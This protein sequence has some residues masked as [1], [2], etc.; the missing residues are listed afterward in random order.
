MEN[1]TIKKTKK[2]SGKWWIWALSI[3]FAGLLVFAY[4][5]NKN[6]PKGEKVTTEK[7]SKRTIYETVSA[8]G[9][10]FPEKEIKISSDVSGEVV[11][12]YV[13]EGDSVKAGQLLAKIN[14]DTYLSAVERGNAGVNNA[15][16]QAAS[17]SAQIETS[18][19]Q[20]EQIEANLANANKIH[21]R[22]IELRKQGVISQADF[23]AS[24][25]NVGALEANLKSAKSTLNSSTQQAKAAEF[26]VKSTEASLKELRTSLSRTSIY[27][28]A[29]GVI[30]KLNIEQ[31]ERVV[32]TIQ[33]AGTE[34]MRIANLSQMEVQVDVSE[35]D[36]L[37]V[38]IG[39]SATIE[40]DAY[41]DRKFKG[42]VTEIA[43]SAS[44]TG[45]SAIQT[46]SSDQVTNFVVKIR[47]NPATYNDMLGNGKFPFR[48]GM[49]AAVEIYTD[50]RNDVVTVP[51]S[52]VTTRED[53]KK[54]STI[55]VKDIEFKEYVFL[56]SSDTAKMV[57]VK[58]GIQDDNFIEILSGLEGNEDV[59][60]GPYA[61]V[62]RKLKQGM[63]LQKDDGK[64]KKGKSGS[65]SVT[66]N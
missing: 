15:R 33:M 5:K 7:V 19:A 10:V 59:I 44:N 9:K 39:D 22:N 65:V 13:M 1:V 52:A 61:T 14:P 17:A 57:R 12:L 43:N 4:I 37:R 66:V 2:S 20:I 11:E 21:S 56:Y 36:I 62:S 40:V 53:E 3:V 24:Q 8:S 29:S 18:K 26:S 63:K 42:V 46:L 34:M 47:I 27:A 50:S 28:P 48:P 49:S 6:K 16:S 41:L 64:D 60:T 58:S 45:T 23:D 31:G 55:K 54:D 35:N 25:A 30:S 51:I 32:G 38:N